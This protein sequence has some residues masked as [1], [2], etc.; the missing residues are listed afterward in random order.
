MT[1]RMSRGVRSPA[2]PAA[3]PVAFQLFEPPL[4]S[5]VE[6]DLPSCEVENPDNEP[7]LLPDD[8]H[9]LKEIG[10]VG[11]LAKLS[12]SSAERASRSVSLG[13][14]HLPKKP[15]PKADGPRIRRF[16]ATPRYRWRIVETDYGSGGAS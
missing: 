7:E 6:R 16:P 14:S 15:T 13:R 12:G 5:D 4:E 3:S 2:G 1:T 10:V 8:S 11:N 9:G